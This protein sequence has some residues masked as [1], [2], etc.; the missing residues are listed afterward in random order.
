MN[1]VYRKGATGALL[2]EYEKAVTELQQVIRDIPDHLLVHIADPLTSDDNCRS[3][4]TVLAHVVSSAYSY[5]IYI[6]DLYH[7]PALRPEKKF[8]TTAADFEKDL[9]DAFLFTTVV[10]EN[11]KDSELEEKKIAARWGQAYDIEQMMEHAIVHV[12]RHRRQLERFR[13]SLGV[14]L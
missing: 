3:V 5:A 12:L 7:P 13:I 1:K 11:I 14:P 6:Q 4:Q 9:S 10:F 8:R 2:D